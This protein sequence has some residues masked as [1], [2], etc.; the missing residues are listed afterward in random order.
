MDLAAELAFLGLYA[1]QHRGQ[2]AAG[3]SAVNEGRTKLHRA[4][5]LIV[6]G[7]DDAAMQSLPGRL[8]LGPRKREYHARDRRPDSGRWCASVRLW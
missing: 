6:D 3:I 7:F 4:H 1:L 5:G 2:E 8:A